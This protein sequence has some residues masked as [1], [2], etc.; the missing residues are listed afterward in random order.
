MDPADYVLLAILV[1]TIPLI[2]RAFNQLNKE[3]RN[4]STRMTIL[5]TLL[6]IYLTHAGFDMSKV[7][8]AIRENMDE[9]K[10]NGGLGVGC[11]NIKELYLD[12]EK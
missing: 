8:K 1:V 12:K 4:H 6:A 11:I 2:V 7:N 5:E 9:L 3:C 10:L